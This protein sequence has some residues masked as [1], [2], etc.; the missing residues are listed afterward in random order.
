M[1]Y[2]TRLKW[3]KTWHAWFPVVQKYQT[4][5]QVYEL[6]CFAIKPSEQKC[7]DIVMSN[8]GLLQLFFLFCATVVHGPILCSFD[9]PKSSFLL[10]RASWKHFEANFESLAIFLKQSAN[11]ISQS[12][13]R[14][15]KWRSLRKIISLSL[16]LSCLCS[17]CT[18]RLL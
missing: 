11:S 5:I 6:Q 16:D 2:K 15:P 17:L 1:F 3:L 13:G 8:H 9:L 4:Y 14:N 12:S 18:W 7:F 10:K